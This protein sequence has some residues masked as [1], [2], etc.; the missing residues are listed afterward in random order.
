MPK[1]PTVVYQMSGSKM[2]KMAVKNK[3][4]AHMK[5]GKSGMG[6]RRKG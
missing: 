6:F 5:R 1:K 2:P 3:V 4:M